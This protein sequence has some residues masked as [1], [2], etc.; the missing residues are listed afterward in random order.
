MKEWSG[1]R[2]QGS[3]F[4]GLRGAMGVMGIM[5]MMGGGCPMIPI[6]PISPIPAFLFVPKPEV[7]VEPQVLNPEP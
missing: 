5:G 1:F 6:T 2:G 4:E 3:G 7:N